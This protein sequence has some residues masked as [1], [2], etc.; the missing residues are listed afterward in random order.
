MENNFFVFTEADL[1]ITFDRFHICTWEFI[2]NS[3][4]IEFGGE[5]N[6][7]N[8][9]T[10]DQITIELFIPWITKKHTV[11]DL[12]NNLK[13]SENSRFIF[14]D[15]V[16]STK[17]LDGGKNKNGVIQE[18]E[19]RKP[20]CIIPIKDSI[21]ADKRTIN[22]QID[23]KPIKENQIKDQ[24]NIY[25]RFYI[26]VS[27]HLLSIRKN[28]ISRSTVI[29]DIKVNEKRNLPPDFSRK[30][31]CKINKC[32]YFNILPNS[33]EMAFYD[34]NALKNVRTLEFDSFKKYLD[35]SRV[36]ENELVV[37]FN[38]KQG[39]ESY[40]FFSIYS[41][42]R[43]GPGQFAL[44]TFVNLICGI[45]L[46]LP[47]HRAG[48]ENNLPYIDLVTRLP[49]EVYISAIIGFTIVIYFIWP[50]I[51]SLY[52]KFISKFKRRKL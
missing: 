47:N 31:F 48:L 29:Y 11:V 20:L 45:L 15:S 34:T 23:L 13:D 22:V 32:F 17:S 28:G 40:S 3:A 33:F 49:V 8:Q 2:N 46:F 43:I 14:N 38:K 10:K 6:N 35:D 25:F 1:N 4:L 36:K 30:S 18:F 27:N 44:A 50:K 26:E 24:T 21:N 41:K 19:E 16:L 12:Y 9:I 39:E 7:F 52:E 51:T 42:E 5:I 37:V